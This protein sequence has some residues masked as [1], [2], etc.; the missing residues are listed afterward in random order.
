MGKI[1]RKIIKINEDLCTGCGVCIPGCPEQA[2]QLVETANGMKARIVKDIYCDGLGACLGTC[3]EGAITI[4]ERDAE[5]YDDNAT[6]ERIHTIAPEMLELHKKHL[7]EHA[8]ELITTQSSSLH[9]CGVC[10]SSQILQWTDQSESSSLSKSELR[11]WPVQLQLIPPSAPF[12]KNTDLIFVADCVPFAYPALHQDL[13]KN[14]AVVV[15]CPKLDDTST[16]TSKIAQIIKT[17]KPKS[18]QIIHMTVACCF[19]LKLLVEDAI[20]QSGFKIPLEEVIISIKGEK[21]VVYISG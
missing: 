10:P 4:E 16:Y 6:I 1:L 5:P 7:E 9:E 20:A 8:N 2:I 11:Q 15:F 19:G 14:K 17:G 13:L 21:N 18:I 3:P 12:L